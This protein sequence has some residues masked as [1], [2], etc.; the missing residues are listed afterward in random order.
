MPKAAPKKTSVANDVARAFML[1]ITVR[2]SKPP[3]WRRFVVDGRISLMELHGVI[4]T[5]MG[6]YDCHLH[7]FEISGRRYTNP[8]TL[9]GFDDEFLD[10][11]EYA[12]CDVVRRQGTKFKYL[13]DFGDGWNHDLLLEDI[14]P[15]DPAVNYPVCLSGKRACPPEDCGGVFGYYNL[16]EILKNPEHPEHKDYKEWAGDLDPNALDLNKINEGLK[17]F[18]SSRVPRLRIR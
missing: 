10:E 13:Y 14:T 1:K 15:L 17:E 6:W 2:G 3:I 11:A 16:L 8:E 7:D 9:D 5:V 4:Q 18:R 12:L